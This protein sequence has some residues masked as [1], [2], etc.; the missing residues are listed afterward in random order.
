MAASNLLVTKAGP[1]TIA[2]ASAMG[3]PC[4]LSS[5]LPG[6]EEGNV[7]FVKEGGFG[8]YRAEPSEIAQLVA[9]YL[10]DEAGLAKMSE[11][12]EKAGRPE[13]TIEIA[14]DLARL[15]GIEAD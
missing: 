13:A 6:Q 1:G 4:V 2:E 9:T 11:A 8:D 12:A 3:L 10:A 7:D 15:V 14:N 5:F